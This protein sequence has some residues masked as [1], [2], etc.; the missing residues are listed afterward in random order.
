MPE[1]TMPGVIT[2]WHQL[3]EGLAA[4]P[5][6]FYA[7]VETAVERRQIPGAVRSR[8]DWHEGGVLSAKREYLRVKRGRHVFDIC[9]APFGA[10]FF[11]SSW[12]VEP[13]S[14]YGPLA[15]VLLLVGL[16]I[17][18]VV[19]MDALGFVKGLLLLIVGFPAL[20]FLV[21]ALSRDIEGWD[22]AL[23]AM[24]VVGPFYERIFR[25][26][27]YY[28]IDTALMF[29]SAVHDA[30]LE[31][32]DGLGRAKGLRALTELERKPTMREFFQ[33]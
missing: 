24:P 2:H 33:R 7:A 25:P 21:N 27:T 23:V 29:Q 9:G 32:V 3:L 26:A 30:V 31:V 11:V 16:L 15:L 19:S 17:A 10:G 28:K 22:D 12:L 4:S 14:P 13:R 5:M 8:V 1:A 20:F 18:I 6:D